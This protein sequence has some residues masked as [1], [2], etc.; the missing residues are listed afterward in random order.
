MKK[1][2]VLVISFLIL[3]LV[4]VCLFYLA[5]SAPD[6]A[7]MVSEDKSTIAASGKDWVN[8]IIQYFPDTYFSNVYD[9]LFH[10]ESG[11]DNIISMSDNILVIEYLG[12]IDEYSCKVRLEKCIRGDADIRMTLIEDNIYKL[13]YNYKNLNIMHLKPG[14]KYLMFINGLPLNSSLV[15]NVTNNRAHV[16]DENGKILFKHLPRN[17]EK[18]IE[19]F[20]NSSYLEEKHIKYMKQMENFNKDSLFSGNFQPSVSKIK[21]IS[22]ELIDTDYSEDNVSATSDSHRYFIR[23]EIT[24]VLFGEL[25]GNIFTTIKHLSPEEIEKMKNGETYAYITTLNESQL[26]LSGFLSDKNILTE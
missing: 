10:T 7:E 25:N 8:N 11:I 1:C 3:I 22:F 18:L 12:E 5:I 24:E 20:E 21:P 19:Y 16:A 15:F 17:S 13:P 26:V 23:F 6:G 4:A 9:V 14:N 2:T